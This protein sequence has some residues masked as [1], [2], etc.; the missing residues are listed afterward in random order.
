MGEMTFRLLVFAIL[1]LIVARQWVA[2]FE[3][4]ENPPP[5]ASGLFFI[6]AALTTGALFT[7]VVMRS[8]LVE[9]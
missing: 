8:A 6:L 9:R 3:D 4:T 1:S 5:V 7:V 2:D